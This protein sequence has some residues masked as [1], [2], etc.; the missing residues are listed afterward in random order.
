ML[1]REPMALDSFIYCYLSISRRITSIT[2]VKIIK[3]NR[4][5]L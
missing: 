5:A 4:K 1:C 2:Q 3:K